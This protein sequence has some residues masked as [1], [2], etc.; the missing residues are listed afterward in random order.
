MKAAVITEHGG[1]EVLEIRDLP[2]PTP[3]PFEVLVDVAASAL[4]RADL[5]QRRG[6]GRVAGCVHT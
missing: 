3:G 6:K 1:P 4:N 2:D 5:L